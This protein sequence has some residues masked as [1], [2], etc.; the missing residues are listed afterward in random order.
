MLYTARSNAYSEIV[1]E[2]TLRPLA[3]S[4]AKDC[5]GHSLVQTSFTEPPNIA[6]RLGVSHLF[7][8]IVH[9][10]RSDVLVVL[11]QLCVCVCIVIM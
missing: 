6:T 8:Y 4:C 1:P 7:V 5:K 11:C 3:T 10:K 2:V 9:F